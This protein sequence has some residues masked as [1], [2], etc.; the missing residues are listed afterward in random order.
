VTGL[1]AGWKRRALV[2]LAGR[3][4]IVSNG[5]CIESKYQDPNGDVRLIQLADIGDGEFLDRSARFLTATKARE[6]NCTFLKPGDLLIARMPD[7]LGRACIFPGVGQPSV[8]AVDV[9]I[10]RAGSEAVNTR[11]LMHA[12]NSPEIRAEIASL[13]S[14]TTR[15]RVSGGN[16]KRLLLPTPPG[17]EQGRIVANLDT[18]LARSR[19]ARE[20]L[21]HISKLRRRYKHAILCAAFRGDLTAEWRSRANASKQSTW[22]AATIGS[23]ALDIRHGTAVKCHYEPRSTPVIR[24]P[25]VSEGRIDTADLKYGEFNKKEIEKLALRPGD[26]LVIRSNGNIDLVGRGALVTEAVAGYVFA[27]YL[28]RLRLDVSQALPEFAAL[29]FEELTIRS[30]LERL[31]KSTSGVHNINSEQLRSL[32]LPL[33]PLPEQSEIARRVKAACSRID[34]LTGEVARAERLLDRFDKAASSKALRDEMGRHG[35]GEER[36]CAVISRS[37]DPAGRR[38]GG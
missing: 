6:L 20:R 2:E 23:L 1:P 19:Q 10:W 9:L 35:E 11:W 7:P 25:N 38:V 14:G 32:V 33:P 29:A 13:A 31:A 18:L 5:D 16:L 21:A 15:Q 24:I 8:T 30:E 3:H 28:I 26:L 34:A 27:G 12:I 22:R 4:G 37:T 17:E 36:A